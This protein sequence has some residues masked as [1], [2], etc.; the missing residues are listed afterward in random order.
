MA[1]ATRNECRPKVVKHDNPRLHAGLFRSR[2][3]SWRRRLRRRNPVRRTIR[4]VS[5]KLQRCKLRRDFRQRG[6][7]K[8]LEAFEDAQVRRTGT[9]VITAG[10]VTLAGRLA[11][12]THHLFAVGHGYGCSGIRCGNDGGWVASSS[13]RLDRR[14]R[15]PNWREGNR[16]PDQKSNN[17]ANQLQATQSSSQQCEPYAAMVMTQLHE[18]AAV[19]Q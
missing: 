5:L 12:L 18:L 11:R 8:N 14:P 6:R 2:S 9:F 13:L 7:A 17:G 1:H 16:Q 10:A 4:L 15:S 19:F 3:G